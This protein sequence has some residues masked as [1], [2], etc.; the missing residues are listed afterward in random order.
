MCHRTTHVS[1]KPWVVVLFFAA[2]LLLGNAWTVG[3]VPPPCPSMDVTSWVER[4][5]SDDPGIRYRAAYSLTG[6]DLEAKETAENLV[7]LL[8]HVDGCVR[9]AA[10]NA[11]GELEEPS[12]RVVEALMNALSD[13]QSQVRNHAAASLA[14]LGD[15]AMQPMIDRLIHLHNRAEMDYYLDDTEELAALLFALANARAHV[16]EALLSP[17][18]WPVESAG[19][20]SVPIDPYDPWHNSRQ[21]DCSL[22]QDVIL[23]LLDERDEDVVS[24]L[25][26]CLNRE[27]EDHRCFALQAL[28]SIGPAAAEA[29][30]D[31]LQ[32][33]QAH[34]GLAIDAMKALV[35][36][37]GVADG[38]ML[39]IAT[40]HPDEVVR[41]LAV[42]ALGRVNDD[43]LAELSQLLIYD[44]SAQVG[45]AAARVLSESMHAPTSEA[46]ALLPVFAR[47]LANDNASLRASLRDI[48][49]RFG[50][51][52]RT[53][54]S[55]LIELLKS[56]DAL[57]G[58][59]LPVWVADAIAAIGH[60]GSQAT[61]DLLL[62][63]LHD[64][65]WAE[66]DVSIIR[67]LINLEACVENALPYLLTAFSDAEVPEKKTEHA[68]ALVALGEEGI[69]ALLEIV[70]DIEV[71][72]ARRAVVAQVLSPHIADDLEVKLAFL[73]MSYC[74]DETTRFL[75]MQSLAL[76]GSATGAVLEWIKG[77]VLSRT[78]SVCFR[79]FCVDTEEMLRT[80]ASDA[81]PL[82]LDLLSMPELS[83]RGWM[84]EVLAGIG[85]GDQ[86]VYE[87]LL[88]GLSDPDSDMRARCA[89]RLSGL[90][91]SHD[92]RTAEALAELL[93]CELGLSEQSLYGDPDEWWFSSRRPW[94]CALL[95]LQKLGP[96]AVSAVPVL[97][98]LLEH[99]DSFVEERVI[100]TLSCIRAIHGDVASA[101]ARR[102]GDR[103]RS[104]R[105]A[106]AEALAHARTGLATGDLL[107]SAIL[108]D[109]FISKAASALRDRA[110]DRFLQAYEAPIHDSPECDPV[111]PV[112]EL[113]DYEF[114]S[115]LE[116]FPWPPPTCA[117]MEAFTDDSL[118][119]PRQ[120][121]GTDDTSL[122]QVHCRL[123]NALFLVDPQF[124]GSFF[125]APGGFVYLTKLERVYPDGL[126]YEDENRWTEGKATGLSLADIVAGLFFSPK[127]YFRN[128]A[129]VVSA[130]RIAEFG[131]ADL[132]DLEMGAADLPSGLASET[133]ED[134]YC[135]VLVY[136][137][138]RCAGGAQTLYTPLSAYD[139]FTKSGVC[140]QLG[141]SELDVCTT[142]TG[143]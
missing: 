125:G 63:L 23:F 80:L 1:R 73:S 86:R 32:I 140:T 129:F 60:I 46:R 137:Y 78:V 79:T 119:F 127:G 134:K 136:A 49:I 8:G 113:P 89:A 5:L 96:R 90:E 36:I 24:E 118:S 47:L 30:E 31:I 51:A 14:R 7:A 61:V 102:L 88:E 83:D 76:G 91:A 143:E 3:Q 44:P 19:D 135:Y 10:A 34:D 13:F 29:R 92:E 82:L 74:L 62:E 121:L 26:D 12:H 15:A 138:E 42:R 115:G 20:P 103:S 18:V 111:A 123:K 106:A 126:P 108:I 84:V 38:Q 21:E 114:P 75:A 105:L 77:L 97:V 141:S 6:I 25:V 66:V 50:R 120:L 70:E 100:Q 64:P 68:E 28:A 142:P 58:K 22:W 81:I 130:T 101:V 67:A 56:V 112:I 95:A 40:S 109:G 65:Q 39:E 71:D 57:H 98:E 131:E 116:P 55:E 53:A 33:L 122:D 37:G 87:A 48:L 107:L 45:A 35:S 99:E 16:L 17:D 72:I 94:D 9:R 43:L 117:H 104:V 4:L 128:M 110:E 52:S 27:S 124:E 85:G 2:S 133:L 59:D 69:R 139:H 54:E 93:R 41:T 132:P 11:L